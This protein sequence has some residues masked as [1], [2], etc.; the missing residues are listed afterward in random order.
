MGGALARA[1]A[2]AG[3]DVLIFDK[4]SALAEATAGELGG[5]VYSDSRALA[6]DADVI[7]LGVKPNI[8][9]EVLD[10]L[11]EAL[12]GR[13]DC[14]LVSMAAGVTLASIESRL[15]FP[16]PIIRIM[17]NTP[18]A[19]GEGMILW[20]KSDSVTDELAKGFT[21]AMSKAGRLSRL[22]EAKIDAGTAVSGCG[23]AFV[24]MFIDALA[25]GGETCGL[26]REEALA[27]ACQTVIGAAEMTLASDRTPTE[28]RDAVCS[29]GGSTIEGVKTLLGKDFATIVE[30][31]VEASYKRT[32]ELGK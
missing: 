22:D 27:Y 21:D 17:P 26:T 31:A 12:R 6:A 3:H 4:N 1:T 32:Q 7:F 5:A 20:C 13:K 29:P 11:C 10:E 15:G 8:V 23:P 30:S 24:Y 18:V 14:L 25:S 28:L 2:G 9:P 16:F 19:V